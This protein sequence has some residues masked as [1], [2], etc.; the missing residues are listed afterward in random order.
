MNKIKRAKLKEAES[1]LIKAKSLIS[2]VRDRE[3]D[4]LDNFPENLQ[5]GE[6]YAAMENAIDELEDAIDNIELASESINN[7]M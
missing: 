2:S 1:F 5:F 4:D 6:R 3:R 7:A